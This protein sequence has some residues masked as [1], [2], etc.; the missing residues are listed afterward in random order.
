MFY[1]TCDRSFIGPKYAQR[2]SC[3]LIKKTQQEKPL[4]K[5][6]LDGSPMTANV[7]LVL[8]LVVGVVVIRFSMY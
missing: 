6:I 4:L 1:F 5:F 7:V 3:R 8:V 2:R